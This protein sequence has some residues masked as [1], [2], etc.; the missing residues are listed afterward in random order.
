M[1]PSSHLRLR[2]LPTG[3][4]AMLIL[5]CLILPATRLVMGRAPANLRPMPLRS[6]LH[7]G[8]FLALKIALVQPIM[9]CGFVVLI[10]ILP[11]IPIAPQLGICGTWFLAFRWVLTDQRSRCPVCLRLLANPVRIG[12]PSQTF[13]E[14]YGAESICSRGH[15][16]LHVSA[17]SSSYSGDPNWLCLDDSWS[18]LF[19][20]T[21]GV[22]HR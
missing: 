7:R 9:L 12:T 14:W 5:S 13:L 1:T 19:S 2:D 3:F 6:R 18:G 16:L 17:I 15:G 20:E 22:R 10:W 8:I 21:V 4:V 11:M